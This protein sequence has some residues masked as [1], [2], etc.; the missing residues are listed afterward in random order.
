MK[1][2][3][4]L[5]IALIALFPTA[6]YAQEVDEMDTLIYQIYDTSQAYLTSRAGR[7]YTEDEYIASDNKLYRVVSVDDGAM[8]AT[9]E[10]IGYEP[11]NDQAAFALV[12]SARAEA[13]KLICMYSTHSDESYEPT[14]GTSSKI[15]DAG[16]FDVGDALK[17]AFEAKGIEVEY[18]KDTFHPHDA[19]AYRRSRATAEEMAKQNPSALLD[20]HRDGIPDPGEYETEVDGEDMTKVRLEVGRSNPNA[21]TNRAFAKQVKSTADE[22]YPGLIKDIFIGKGNYN[23]ELYPKALLV[24][25]GTHTSDKE[26][27]IK[28]T[29]YLADVMDEVLFGP[30][31]KAAAPR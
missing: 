5:L 13:K 7:V 21:S 25:L 16:I 22:Q 31:A 14:D 2:C 26:D 9:A 17:D 29:T 15:D 23:Q 10:Y 27:V 1:K 24:E 8:V 4:C 11:E 12:A 30:T 18:S 28:S 20:L 3:I 19:G 6:V